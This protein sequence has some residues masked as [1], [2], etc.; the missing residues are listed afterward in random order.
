MF[1]IVMIAILCIAGWL[2][3]EMTK[4]DHSIPPN[5]NNEWDDNNNH[6]EGHFN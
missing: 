3:Y 4:Q 6:T 2:T 1:W 5:E